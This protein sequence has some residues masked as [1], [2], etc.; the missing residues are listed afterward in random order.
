MIT[1]SFPGYQT[2]ATT[3]SVSY[4]V[5][6]NKEMSSI[7]DLVSVM[8]TGAGHRRRSS[9]KNEATRQGFPPRSQSLVL[10]PGTLSKFSVRVERPDW[11]TV[12]KPG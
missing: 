6:T 2:A 1:E 9:V 10:F 8:M 3:Q 4:R 5:R 12:R 7:T 11:R